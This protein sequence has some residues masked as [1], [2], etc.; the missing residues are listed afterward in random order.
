[1]IETFDTEAWEVRSA[2]LLLSPVDLEG[3]DRDLNTSHGFGYRY[4]S[5][6]APAL[7]DGSRSANPHPHSGKWA[8]DIDG[9]V[10][11]TDIPYGMGRPLRE[12]RE[13]LDA[14]LQRARDLVSG[15]KL[16]PD[17][18]NA[19]RSPCAAGL[20]LPKSPAPKSATDRAAALP[21][22]HAPQKPD[23][24]ALDAALDR[25]HYTRL[26]QWLLSNDVDLTVSERIVLADVL[27]VMGGSS[28]LS[29][30]ARR[31]RLYNRTG[32]K[33]STVTMAVRSLVAKGALAPVPTARG[34][35]T[36]SWEA[37]EGMA[38]QTAAGQRRL[39][40]ALTQAD[41]RRRL[42]DTSRGLAVP[43]WAVQLC[44]ATEAALLLAK[45][46]AMGHGGGDGRLWASGATLSTWLPGCERSLR[47]ARASLA[48]QGL[49]C[50][51]G[52]YTYT[53]LYNAQTARNKTVEISV[54]APMVARA[55]V[56]RGCDF[57][58]DLTGVADAFFA[59][60]ASV[61]ADA[62]AW[63]ASCALK[64]R[65]RNLRRALALAALQGSPSALCARAMVDAGTSARAV[66]PWRPKP[67]RA[68]P[69][70]A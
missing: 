16:S 37:L 21:R 61:R 6:K 22:A 59:G 54:T 65:L 51:T 27:D 39:G 49:A 69:P 11:V 19:R 26:P 10:F 7:L 25:A 40:S 38:R 13:V 15:G 36:V 23:V 8:F 60:D 14:T 57:G 56:V 41:V 20:N 33:P 18:D 24:R 45:A 53:R 48:E 62:A 44:G 35:F 31:D 43:I 1:M 55:L 66:A 50:L 58:A 28:A 70:A 5:Q 30:E 34:R 52:Q 68:L 42:S 9:L 3:L 46:W 29:Y 67:L 64:S 47:R 32:L 17:S 4:L 2:A 12:A 63:D